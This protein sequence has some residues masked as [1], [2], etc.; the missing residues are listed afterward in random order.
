[1]LYLVSQIVICLLIAALLG[2]AIGWWL[3]S[4]LCG[5]RLKPVSRTRDECTARLATV[6]QERDS[7]RD[8]VQRLE[9]ET[10]DLRAQILLLAQQPGAAKRPQT[11]AKPDRQ[12]TTRAPETSPSAPQPQAPAPAEPAEPLAS[13]E[14][15]PVSATASAAEGHD[16]PPTQIEDYDVEE[17]AGVGK[18]Y[19]KRLR[20]MHI[21][22]SQALLAQGATAEGRRKIAEAVGVDET[23]VRRWVSMADLM[24]VPGVMGPFAELL[25]A[26]GVASIQDL[27][28]QSAHPLTARMRDLNAREHRAKI[29][30]NVD[31]VRDWI[32]IA[33]EIPRVIS[34]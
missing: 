30:P 5:A 34:T 29:E 10:Q 19:G 16:K 11:A 25:E 20:A 24:R 1:M 21:T 18:G 15:S 4:L 27:A 7:L 33:R 13:A 23:T 3:R 14:Q 26:T 2:F 32:A 9:Y 28:S 31:M 12:P 22:T 6:Q 8:Q 17:I